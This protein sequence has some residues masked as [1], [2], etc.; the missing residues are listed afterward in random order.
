MPQY[1]DS[2]CHLDFAAFDPDRG[3]VWEQ[4]Q[5]HGVRALFVPG[6]RLE[7]W[8]AL[9][10]LKRQIPTLCFGVGL[11]P[12][13]LHEQS[14]AA[15]AVCLQQLAER[16]SALGAAAI[17]EC[18]LDARVPERGGLALSEQETI[19]N[20]QLDV[21]RSLHLPVV[22]HV[23]GAHGRA[24]DLL[25]RQGPLPAGGVLHAYSGSAELVPRYAAL[26]LS[27]GFGGALTR[28]G[29]RK[30]KAA[31]AVV[32]RDRLLLETDAPD[33]APVGFDGIQ[34]GN[35]VRNEPAAITLI[36]HTVCEQLGID[37]EDLARTTT[38]NALTLFAGAHVC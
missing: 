29:A 33:Q 31:L 2:H 8:S 15:R 32:P 9:P 12:Y 10:E 20:A 1:F 4:A 19:L 27:F 7:Q 38:N 30:V 36:A 25:E 26:G 24:L 21:A 11:H 17:G 37:A 3:A 6:I 18:G 28:P 34:L 23:V 16:A 14:A 22:L 35:G 5:K 13:F